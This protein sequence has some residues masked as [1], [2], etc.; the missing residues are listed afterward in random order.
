MILARRVASALTGVGISGII[1]NS[2]VAASNREPDNLQSVNLRL[3]FLQ[4]HGNPRP[5]K[6]GERI[7]FEILHV[8][9]PLVAKHA[10]RDL[11]AQ[12]Q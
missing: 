9:H 3:M 6:P 1:A 2:E 7:A 5:I 4:L 12:L 10:Y 11:L 8:G